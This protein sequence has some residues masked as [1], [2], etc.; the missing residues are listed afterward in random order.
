MVQVHG[1]WNAWVV[2][3]AMELSTEGSP[4]GADSSS[5]HVFNL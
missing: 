3:Q 1:N 5:G 4:H 2:I